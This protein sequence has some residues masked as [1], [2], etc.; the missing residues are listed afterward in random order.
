MSPAGLSQLLR[1]HRPQSSDLSAR[2][3]T[4]AGRARPPRVS[5]LRACPSWSDAI[6]PDTVAKPYGIP[7]GLRCMPIEASATQL[8]TQGLT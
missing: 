1:T 2:P 5:P 7:Y 3:T 8:P 4:V 6:L